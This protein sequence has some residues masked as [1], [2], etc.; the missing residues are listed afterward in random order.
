LQLAC[1][2]AKLYEAQARILKLETAAAVKEERRKELE[3]QL[4]DANVCQEK[5]T[6]EIA[7]L[8]TASSV[9]QREI[10]EALAV[11]AR[12]RA[13]KETLQTRLF[14]EGARI[15]TLEEEV[16]KV[17][18]QLGKIFSKVL[19]IVASHSIHTRALT[20]ENVR[21]RREASRGSDD[22]G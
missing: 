3:Q 16:A 2:A 1:T 17:E 15:K 14:G 10:E 12:L 18:K 20:F 19:Y 4:S 7:A 9:V 21:V 8:K 6:A 11:G 22:D 5:M 13:E